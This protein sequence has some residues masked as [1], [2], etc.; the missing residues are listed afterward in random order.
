[1]DDDIVSIQHDLL[2]NEEHHQSSHQE[3]TI[4]NRSLISEDQSHE[5]KIKIFYLHQYKTLQKQ[6]IKN[7]EEQKKLQNKPK[8]QLQSNIEQKN[9]TIV[10]YAVI[11]S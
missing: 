5:L 8:R 7:F 11:H 4:Y 1:M 10:P 6:R 9:I 2:Y 3:S